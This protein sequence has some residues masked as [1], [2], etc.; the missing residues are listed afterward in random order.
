MGELDCHSGASMGPAIVSRGAASVALIGNPNCGKSTI[1]N[2]LTGLRQHV[3]NWPGKTVGLAQGECL[4]TDPACRVVDLPGI[5]SLSAR[6]PEEELAVEFVQEDVADVYLAVLDATNL[7]RNLYLLVQLLEMTGRVIVALN[8]TDVA[9]QSGIKVDVSAL[10]ARLGG[11]PFVRTAA[12]SGGGL[13]ELKRVIGQAV[14]AWGRVA[15]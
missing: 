4:E 10:S 5:Y 12:A 9:R 15:G 13:E 2:A 11:V 14:S 1:F 7:E 8:M 3:A 6:S